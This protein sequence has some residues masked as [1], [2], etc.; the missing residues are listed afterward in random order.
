MV[1]AVNFN[2]SNYLVNTSM[3]LRQYPVPY[4]CGNISSWYKADALVDGVIIVGYSTIPDID[5]HQLRIMHNPSAGV[6]LPKAY[7]VV[8]GSS[9]FSI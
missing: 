7:P 1:R 3:G 9:T 8:P 2:G 6:M 5:E 4:A